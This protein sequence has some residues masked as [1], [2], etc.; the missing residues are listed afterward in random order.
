VDGN[1]G[2]DMLFQ[3]EPIDMYS[4]LENGYG[5]FTGFLSSTQNFTLTPTSLQ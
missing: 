5:I 1:P 3:G 2:L 4:N